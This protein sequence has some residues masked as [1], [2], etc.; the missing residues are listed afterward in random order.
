MNPSPP[1]ETLRHTHRLKEQMS[2]LIGHLRADVNKVAD[3]RA[4]ALFET[5]AEVIA[6][7]VKTFG[8][9]EQKTEAAWKDSESQ[10]PR[11]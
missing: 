3:P 2:E 11:H 9:Y 7:L 5:S 1:D 4:K 6:S 10:P 8:H